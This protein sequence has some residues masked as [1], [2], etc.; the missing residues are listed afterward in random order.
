MQW[1]PVYFRDTFFAALSLNHGV[2]SFFDGYV[3]Q[4]TPLPIFFEQYERAL[5]DSLQK[6][7]Q[8]DFETISTTPPLKTPSPM[9]QQASTLYT[10]NVFAKFQEELVETFVYTAHKVDGGGA[11]NKYRITRFEN[12]HNSYIVR[13]HVSEMKASCSCQMF[14][15]SGV[16][17]RHIL[18][19]FRV[20]NILTLPPQFVLQRW[21]TSAKREDGSDLKEK[22]DGHIIESLSYRFSN[23][24]REA[25]KFSEAGA[26][27]AETY[28]A[29]MRVLEEG[30]RKVDVVKKD[31]AKIR[32]TTSQLSGN[33]QESNSKKSSDISPLWPWQEPQ[34]NCFN[35]DDVEVP[36]ANLRQP[37]MA[38]VAINH[39]GKLADNTI[40]LTCFKSMTWVVENKVPGG[41]VAVINLKLQDCS[42]LSGED[43]VEFRLTR[44]TLIPMLR[45][46][47]YIN[48]QFTLP[49]NKVAVISLRLQD[50]ETTAGETDVKFQVSR[51]TLGSM[52]R[53]MAYIHELL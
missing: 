2:G 5:D 22:I 29:A 42:K 34:P 17:C 32:L 35:L 3:N 13:L 26:I 11:E 40:V 50:T 23:L 33:S 10:K 30:A 36:I 46:L 24:C 52:L 21:T 20:T 43:N 51:D 41:K 15:Y 53:S 48:Q 12:A 45:S 7:I 44:V 39:N 8:A 14:E 27:S 1:A 6:E 37:T 4:H 19:V 18:T 38:P 16:L 28:S 31:T 9:E 25:L 47:A 49:T